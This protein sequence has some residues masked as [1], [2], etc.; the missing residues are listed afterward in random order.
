MEN[1]TYVTLRCGQCE[2]PSCALCPLETY[3]PIE[4]KRGCTRRM[5]E[6]DAAKYKHYIEEVLPFLHKAKNKEAM[7]RIYSEIVDFLFHVYSLP[8]GTK[9]D[10]YG[11]AI[12]K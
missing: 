4:S 12:G 10:K 6:I 5:S 1:Y 11:K 7:S 2:N 3:I 8:L 9:L